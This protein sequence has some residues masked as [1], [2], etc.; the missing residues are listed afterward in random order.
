[1]VAIFAERGMKAARKHGARGKAKKSDDSSVFSDK[2]TA[3]DAI[4]AHTGVAKETVARRVKQ[5]AMLFRPVSTFV[6]T[7]EY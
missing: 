5:A 2:P 7:D 1:M 4:A 6:E 3:V